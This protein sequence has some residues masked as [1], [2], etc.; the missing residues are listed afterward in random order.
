MS[1]AAEASIRHAGSQE[2]GQG[3][4]QQQAFPRPG[5]ARQLGCS[6]LPLHTANTAACTPTPKRSKQAICP[7][8]KHACTGAHSW[9][10]VPQQQTHQCTSHCLRLRSVQ[11]TGSPCQGGHSSRDST[12]RDCK[13]GV[14]GA[15]G[16]GCRG[17]HECRCDQLADRR[18][19]DQSA[20]AL[21]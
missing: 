17:V 12:V 7:A 5:E 10:P 4:Q 6:S 19:C 21:R 11:N 8:S 2:P 14:G 1:A 15:R 13:A 9:L 3:S 20:T 18:M 16:A